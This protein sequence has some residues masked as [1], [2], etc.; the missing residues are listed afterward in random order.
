MFQSNHCVSL[1]IAGICCLLLACDPSSEEVA[2]QTAAVQDALSQAGVSVVKAKKRKKI[3]RKK[4]KKKLKHK[5]KKIIQ[6]KKP[7]KQIL[8]AKGTYPTDTTGNGCA[9]SC[10]QNTLRSAVP[11]RQRPPP[12]PPRPRSMR[13]YEPISE[14]CT[15]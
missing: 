15:R 6:A 10:T 11:R 3:K 5:L 13:A 12:T 4:L 1:F 7:C 8:C 2:A 14:Q 9:N